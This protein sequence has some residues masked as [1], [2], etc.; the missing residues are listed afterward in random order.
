[1]NKAGIT[2]LNAWDMVSKANA[3]ME[4]SRKEMLQVE[5]NTQLL[6]AAFIELKKHPDQPIMG[7]GRTL[8]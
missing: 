4:H 8:D 7:S 5:Y 3:I 6:E 2:R 1:M